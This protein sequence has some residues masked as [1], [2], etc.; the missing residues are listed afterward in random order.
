MKYCIYYF[1]FSCITGRIKTILSTRKN[2]GRWFEDVGNKA[3]SAMSKLKRKCML[4]VTRLQ[5]G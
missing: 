1:S 4:K 2:I 5:S 3:V